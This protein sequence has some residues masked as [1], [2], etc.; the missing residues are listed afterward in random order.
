M[1][2]NRNTNCWN[3]CKC[4]NFGE[5]L[6]KQKILRRDSPLFCTAEKGQK[7]VPENDII[8]FLTI[9]TFYQIRIF[10]DWYDRI[11]PDRGKTRCVEGTINL[12]KISAAFS[13]Q[14]GAQSPNSIRGHKWKWGHNFKIYVLTLQ[15][16]VYTTYPTTS[17]TVIFCMLSVCVS[18]HSQTKRLSLSWTEYPLCS[19]IE[20]EFFCVVGKNLLKI[21]WVTITLLSQLMHPT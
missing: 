5:S 12:N 4:H 9:C 11:G 15:T 7:K 21:T 19:V 2:G 8:I 1:L 20:T 18:F 16:P 17:I 3:F 10:L 13:D 14:T 6:G